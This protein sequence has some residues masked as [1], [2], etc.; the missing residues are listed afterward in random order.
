MTRHETFIAAIPPQ[1]IL[2]LTPHI[3]AEIRNVRLS[4]NLSADEV[5]ELLA[6]LLRHKVLFFRGQAHLDDAEQERFA[7]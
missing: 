3:G 7:L 4:G 6:L 2:A 1:D 5:G